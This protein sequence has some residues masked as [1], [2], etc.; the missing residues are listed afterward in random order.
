MLYPLSYGSYVTILDS[1]VCHRARHAFANE[2]VAINTES[3]R[4]PTA[5]RCAP[6][7]RD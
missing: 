3:L 5:R 6:E 1:I 2:L 7:V 4:A